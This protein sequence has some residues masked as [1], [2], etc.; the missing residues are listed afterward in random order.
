M[1]PG[2]PLQPEELYRKS[3]PERSPSRPPLG[4]RLPHQRAGGSG[5]REGSR[6]AG[7][8]SERLEREA[9]EVLEVQGARRLRRV[10][11][12][13]WREHPGCD[14]RPLARGLLVRDVE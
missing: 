3:A 10:S 8:A 14:S 13:K 12:S 2:E 11:G 9:D 7:F 1:K 5:C 4:P 6:L